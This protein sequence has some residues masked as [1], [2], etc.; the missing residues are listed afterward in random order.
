LEDSF[1]I[2]ILLSNPEDRSVAK[3]VAQ[4]IQEFYFT[5]KSNSAAI[6]SS[7]TDVRINFLYCSHSAKYSMHVQLGSLMVREKLRS[8]LLANRILR[9]ISKLQEA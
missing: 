7:A 5:D 8:K 3:N 2:T 6:F 1:L 4:K 9:G